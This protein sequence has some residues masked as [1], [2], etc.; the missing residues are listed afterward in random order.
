MMQN[1]KFSKSIEIK[2][3]FVFFLKTVHL[4]I[5][6]FTLLLIQVCEINPRLF[7]NLAFHLQIKLWGKLN[8]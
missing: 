4:K 2:N 5:Y 8:P 7:M 3:I 1:L 6:A